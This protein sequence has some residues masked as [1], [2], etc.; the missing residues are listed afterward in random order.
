MT[1]LSNKADA[2]TES[3]TRPGV[4]LAASICAAVVVSHIFGRFSYSLLLPAISDDLVDTF[5]GAGFLGASYFAGYMIG[6]VVVT[7]ISSRVEPLTLLRSGLALSAVVLT[8]LAAAPSFVALAAGIFFAGVAGAGI[9]IPAPVIASSR[10]PVRHRGLVMGALTASMGGGLLLVSQGTTLY[11]SA[12]D[13]EGAWRPVFG[14]EAVA[15][16]LILLIVAAVTRS[17]RQPAPQVSDGDAAQ[18]PM[19]DLSGLRTIPSWALLLASYCIFALLAGSWSQFLGLALEEDAGFSR[20]HINNLFSAFAL[21][22]VPGPLLFGRLSDRI[23]RDRSLSLA[24][25]LCVAASLMIPLGA[26]PFA[27]IA[28]FTFGAGSFA[29]PPVTAAAVRDHLDGRVFGATFGG[30][31]IVY[32]LTSMVA[33]QIG[34]V[35][36]DVTGSFD[37][38]YYALAAAAALA[39][40]TAELR[41]RSLGALGN[42]AQE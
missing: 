36:A 14:A 16:A 6:V 9:W 18:G 26:E 5:T 33:S 1:D 17:S 30:M 40:F 38:W 2:A 11:R 39:A 25:L 8:L 22:A 29:V 7:A 19:F 27:T 21:G 42:T 13:D 37:A 3:V 15:T 28:A 34:G 31:T 41:R 32:A 4:V 24:C 23:G 10:L 12:T 35:V 20:S